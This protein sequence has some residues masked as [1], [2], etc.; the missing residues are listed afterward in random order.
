MTRSLR[1]MSDITYG[2]LVSAYDPTLLVRG[3][4]SI[5]ITSLR[6]V[7]H[8][9][10]TDA[11]VTNEGTRSP[12]GLVILAVG[13]MMRRRRVLILSEFLPG[14]RSGVKGKVVT[15]FYR[16]LLPRV[17]TGVQVMTAWEADDYVQR[18]RLPRNVVQHIPFYSWDDRVEHDK[19]QILRSS[20]QPAGAPYLFASGRN[21]CDW[22][23][24]LVAHAAAANAPRL[25]VCCTSRDLPVVRKYASTRVEV[26]HDL[27]REQHDELLAGAAAYLVI[28]RPLPVSCG[29]VRLMSAATLGVPVIAALV[30]G[31]RGY[32]HLISVP[33]P[34][35]DVA[36]LSDTLSD[37]AQ[38]PGE[39]ETS[40]ARVRAQALTRPR[41]QYLDELIA[42]I[43]QSAA[44]EPTE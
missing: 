6:M 4:R 37:L 40:L 27:P 2:Q 25:V 44:W 14:T 9:H 34:A 8:A 32:E 13:L 30:P 18:Y 43:H 11:I 24:L 17:C 29:H 23:T 20:K 41:K 36:T 15:L 3:R 33:V 42:F 19:T 22:P 5:V 12:L 7:R 21:A 35:G 10:T 39:L 16:L 38:R 26:H 31:V 1:A 28:L